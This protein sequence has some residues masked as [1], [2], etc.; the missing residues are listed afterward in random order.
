MA[1]NQ[2]EV[3]AMHISHHADQRMNQRGISRRLDE[4]ALRHGRIEGNKHILDRNESRKL[5]DALTE[6]LRLAKRAPRSRPMP[7]PTSS[8]SS[9]RPRTRCPTRSRR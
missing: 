2:K 4:F 1:S 8:R 5:I 7:R 6:E 3:T 9:P